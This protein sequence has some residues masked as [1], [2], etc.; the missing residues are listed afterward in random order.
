MLDIRQNKRGRA[1]LLVAAARL[2][3]EPMLGESKDSRQMEEHN[4]QLAV[5]LEV[6]HLQPFLE[7]LFG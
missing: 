1:I 4:S 5:F 6:H 7:V 3:H 2:L